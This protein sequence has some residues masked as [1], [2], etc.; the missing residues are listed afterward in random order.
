MRLAVSLEPQLH[1]SFSMSTESKADFRSTYAT[2]GG[3]LNSRCRSDRRHCART[4][5]DVD[6]LGVNHD[7]SGHFSSMRSG[8]TR[9]STTLAKTLQGTERRV[10]VLWL[11]QSEFGPFP[12][13]RKTMIPSLHSA[14]TL[15]T[16]GPLCQIACA[17]QGL[18]YQWSSRT[19]LP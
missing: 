4:A 6:L 16:C 1:E 3:L 9:D 8:S 17:V 13:Y 12:L 18:N 7:C 10:M 5:S 2:Y 11:P 15:F 14:G 19:F